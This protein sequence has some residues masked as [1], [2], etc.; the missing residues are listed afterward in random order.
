MFLSLL[1]EDFVLVKTQI[2]T[3]LILTIQ[4]L[5]LSSLPRAG[6]CVRILLILICYSA[7]FTAE[8]QG[9]L[10]LHSFLKRSSKRDW[11]YYTYYQ[12]HSQNIRFH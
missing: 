2:D 5:S 7:A 8:R 4:E 6:L 10:H 11:L 9:C 12:L 3:T 1:M